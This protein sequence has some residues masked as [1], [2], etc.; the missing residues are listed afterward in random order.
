MTM[1]V[2]APSTPSATPTSPAP[3]V[4]RSWRETVRLYYR[5]TKPR[6]I[7]LLLITTL[8]AMFIASD[9]LPSWGLVFVTMLAG[10]FMAGGS[11]AI[12]AYI[13]RDIDHLMKRTRTRPV[14]SGQIPAMH[15]LV[16]GIVLG[17]SGF[18]LYA[19]FVNLLTAALGLA[20]LLFYVFVYSLWLKRITVQNIVI[21]GA[22]GAFPP[23]VGW[24][25][26]AHSLSP[27]AVVLFAII[28][29][30]TPPHFWALALVMRKDY[31]EAGIP[32][33]PVV[34]GEAR[35]V[36]QIVVYTVLLILATLLLAVG[37]GM[38]TVYLAAAVLLGAGFGY[39]VMRLAQG[40]GNR[41]AK[42]LFHYSNAY[43]ALLFLLM[44]IDHFV[45]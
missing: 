22:A 39:Y 10:A 27:A 37:N 23:L 38:G 3:V 29:L 4:P 7:P 28:F 6:I 13:D 11:H 42:R 2:A 9:R 34:V 16:F 32:M 8:C 40:G 15:A 33:L 17:A 24:A 45:R 1:H 30:W 41:A 44:V 25:A 12:N 35:T 20:G 19:V 36:R 14:V 18:A 43:L 5:V 21:G 31:A 26:V